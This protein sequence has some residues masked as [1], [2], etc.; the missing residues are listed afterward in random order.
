MSGKF[1]Y[2]YNIDYMD[3][4]YIYICIYII[5]NINYIDYIYIYIYRLFSVHC[6]V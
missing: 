4:I 3:Y 5:F 1:I 6:T 2:I